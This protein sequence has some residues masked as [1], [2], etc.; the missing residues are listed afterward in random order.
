MRASRTL[1]GNDPL[2]LLCAAWRVPRSSVYPLRSAPGGAE[3]P[4][5]RGP[6][7]ALSD[8]ELVAEIRTALSE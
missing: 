7:T 2:K 6:K 3:Q 4:G 5:K 1:A 8:E